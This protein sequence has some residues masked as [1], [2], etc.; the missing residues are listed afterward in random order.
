M[1]G[2]SEFILLVICR[3]VSGLGCFEFASHLLYDVF[4][5]AIDNGFV[6]RSFLQFRQII[7]QQMMG[8]FSHP[9]IHAL[10]VLEQQGV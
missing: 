8:L 3:I 7:G 2:E 4:L 6:Q 9:H 10:Q 5:D 1:L